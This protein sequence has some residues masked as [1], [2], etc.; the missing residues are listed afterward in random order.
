M[1]CTWGSKT[2]SAK[3]IHKT[4]EN[5]MQTAECFKEAGASIHGVACIIVTYP[6]Q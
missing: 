1:G 4:E 2:A 6:E 5:D 3:Q